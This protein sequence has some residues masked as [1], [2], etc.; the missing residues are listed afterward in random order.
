MAGARGSQ[1]PAPGW[2]RGR[3]RVHRAPRR[4]RERRFL[5]LQDVELLDLRG[6]GEATAADPGDEGAASAAAVATLRVT[7]RQAVYLTAAGNFA[8]EVRL[9]PARRATARGAVGRG[10]R[11]LCASVQVP[12][13]A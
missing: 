10:G 5:A 6:A 12:Q 13:S 1:A 4:G 3:A 2:A 11:G 7:L 9:L 8:R